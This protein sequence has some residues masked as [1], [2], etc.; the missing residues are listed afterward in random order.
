[1][2]IPGPLSPP[3]DTAPAATMAL[4]ELAASTPDTR[5]ESAVDQLL[6][7]NRRF[8]DTQPGVSMFSSSGLEFR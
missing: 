1:M 6:Q 8:V 7:R 3:C 4:A 5:I 2:L